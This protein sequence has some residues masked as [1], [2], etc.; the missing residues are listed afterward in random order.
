VASLE[1]EGLVERRPDPL[2]GRASLLLLSARGKRVSDR[3]SRARRA[4]FAE[5]LSEWPEDDVERFGHLLARFARALA[6]MNEPVQSRGA[7]HRERDHRTT[8]ITKE[9]S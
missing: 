8:P 9:S 3:L 1:H 4:M 7:A 6:G 2:D 5:V